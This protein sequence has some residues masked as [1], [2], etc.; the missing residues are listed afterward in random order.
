MLHYRSGNLESVNW[1]QVQPPHTHTLH[2]HT[3]H[4]FEQHSANASQS[5]WLLEAVGASCYQFLPQIRKALAVDDSKLTGLSASPVVVCLQARL[6][7]TLHG[8]KH[9]EIKWSGLENPQWCGIRSDPSGLTGCC[10]P[11]PLWLRLS[12]ARTT[13]P[14]SILCLLPDGLF[15]FFLF[16]KRAYWLLEGCNFKSRKAVA[17]QESSEKASSLRLTLKEKTQVCFTTLLRLKPEEKEHFALFCFAV[18][19]FFSFNWFLK[20]GKLFCLRQGVSETFFWL[21]VF[22]FSWDTGSSDQLFLLFPSF[23]AT[24]F[25]ISSSVL[26]LTFPISSPKQFQN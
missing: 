25:F 26:A 17:L 9:A 10:L 6:F 2:S 1:T 15:L 22:S 23:L 5:R 24:F 8:G 14:S 21:V 4:W 13:L 18:L 16:L 3:E 11:L 7:L 20:R 12:C 19:S